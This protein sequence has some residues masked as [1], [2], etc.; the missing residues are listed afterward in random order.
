MLE[1]FE[2]CRKRIIIIIMNYHTVNMK[3]MGAAPDVA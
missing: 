2:N 1:P 3:L